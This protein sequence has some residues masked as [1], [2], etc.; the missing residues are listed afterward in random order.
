MKFIAGSITFTKIWGCYH[1]EVENFKSNLLLLKKQP[2]GEKVIWTL[3]NELSILSLEKMTIPYEAYHFTFK[4]PASVNSD[5]YIG[6]QT[7]LDQSY[8]NCII[9]DINEALHY[10]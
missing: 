2:G 1:G 5:V 6:G 8:I 7:I 3:M 9:N 4:F 10:A